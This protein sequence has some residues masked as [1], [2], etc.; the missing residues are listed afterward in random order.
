MDTTIT[1]VYQD[2]IKGGMSE[3][4]AAKICLGVMTMGIFDAIEEPMRT[5]MVQDFINKQKRSNK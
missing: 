2:Y 1:E 5:D 4:K 3:D